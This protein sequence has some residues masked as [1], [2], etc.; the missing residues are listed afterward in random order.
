[1]PAL[2][3]SR[4]T[5]SGMVFVVIQSL[6]LFVG[7]S[8]FLLF[9]CLAGILAV[10]LMIS[11]P[12]WPN[13]VFMP[14]DMIKA[15]KLGQPLDHGYTGHWSYP[16]YS[17]KR[18]DV[19]KKKLERS[20][21]KSI[22]DEEDEEPA[23]LC[24]CGDFWKAIRTMD[25]IGMGFY[26]SVTIFNYNFFLGTASE[27]LVLKGDNGDYL[28][29]FAIIFPAGV[30]FLPLISC[31]LDRFKRFGLAIMLAAIAATGVIYGTILLIPNL[32]V[33]MGMFFVV[34]F[35]RQAF[36][37]ASFAFVALKFDFQLYGRL[38][39]MTILIGGLSTLFSYVLLM[40]VKSS[41][42]F[43]YV[44]VGLLC[45]T[46][47]TVLFPIYVAC[48]ECKKSKGKITQVSPKPTD[49]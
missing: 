16:F 23:G 5:L 44:N 19:K 49:S 21:S 28:S 24:G 32:E 17:V 40:A 2:C 27:Q 1:M 35:H 34:S 18:V 7:L 22:F 31:T 12:L 29:A 11:L 13:K 25:F 39:G 46:T 48:L 3:T 4:F 10:F 6:S 43:F 8:R 15:R 26:Y 47:F 41:G 33:M 42:S 20:A 14:G 38:S 45:T 36:S 9:G 37:T 30:I